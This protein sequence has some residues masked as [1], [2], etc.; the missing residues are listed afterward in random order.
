MRTWSP[1]LLA[2][3]IIGAT[4]PG[5]ALSHDKARSRRAN[6]VAP[7]VQLP[8][9]FAENRGQFAPEVCFQTR[10]PGLTVNV[11]KDGWS[12]HGQ[13]GVALRVRFEGAVASAR[14]LG[15]DP[16]KG[17][18]NYISG[19]E[20]DGWVLG[21]PMFERVRIEGLR[22]DVD[23][24]MFETGGRLEYD[25]LVGPGG[26]PGEI[27]FALEGVEESRITPDGA[28]VAVC[29]GREIR[30]RRPR[31]WQIHA[32]GLREEL[33]S[34]FRQVGKNR[35]G[36]TVEGRDPLLPLVI[37]PL[38]LY[39]EFVGG[40]SADEAH[41]VAVGEDGAVY[42][43]GWAKSSD[44]PLAE[45]RRRGKDA[46]VFKLDAAGEAIEYA[47]YLGGENDEEAHA[48][49]VNAAGEV[50]IVGETR[51]EYFPTTEDAFQD[52]RAGGYDVF[53]LRLSADGGALLYSTF[54]GGRSDDSAHGLAVS[55]GNAYIV[56]TTRSGDYPTS[57]HAV[58]S[59][60]Q[61]GRDAFVT[62][63][64]SEGRIL[65]YS[66]LLGGLRDDRGFD[67]AVDDGGR[68]YV[69]GRTESADF[70]T[71]R[72][73]FDRTK[74]SADVFVSKLAAG[75][76]TLVY[77]TFLGGSG[78]EEGRSI[79]VDDEGQAYVVGWTQSH[80][81]PITMDAL[82]RR[83]RRRDGFI[84]RLSASGGA[85]GYSTFYGGA[86]NDEALGVTLDAAGSPWFVGH[87]WSGDLPISRDAAQERPGGGR[88]AFL[89]SLDP[90]SGVLSFGTYL[91][92]KGDETAL[93]VRLQP[94]TPNV[95][96]A[97]WADDIPRDEQGVMAGGAR[98]PSDA[99]V[100][101]YEPGLC[102]SPAEIAVIGSPCGVDI[103]ATLPRLGRI[104]EL[105]I[106]APPLA[107][108]HVFLS[109]QSLA[110][111]QVEGICE[112]HI[113]R[114]SARSVGSFTADVEGNYLFRIRLPKD[115]SMCGKLYVLQV[116]TFAQDIGPL[117]FG[118]LSQGLL[119]S[120]GD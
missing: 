19:R 9:V 28:L 24:E 21:A 91:G 29:N 33:P 14:P 56:G 53:A 94:G 107:R 104:F 48:V 52:R 20:E 97:G 110:S 101:R 32:H 83:C 61:G 112:L 42:V 44:F 111:Y 26:E 38:L 47:T 86:G 64:D 109:G 43:V 40:S 46:V 75:G 120:P 50:F 36:F 41:A 82:Q 55:E 23:L 49:E 95:V 78:Q 8:L 15:L 58:Q 62:K 65:I 68:A 69:T 59:E 2:L 18:A 115:V 87:T 93:S 1:G 96:L 77:S 84:M 73:A 90:R 31:S 81:F 22:P 13:D 27:V 51:S 17:V 72:N 89:A 100:A 37:D 118:Q 60:R 30:Q 25:L 114:A 57:A 85:L 79:A 74:N 34:S 70:P 92:G 105:E 5:R 3:L 11:L 35:Y 12:L 98:G 16:L 66:T 39:S 113:D 7:A 71:T 4:A 103:E 45:A 6:T 67:V 108:G 99:L 119:L 88:D 106:K 10:V 54:I 76:G 63:L 117:S 102:G 116:A 80:D